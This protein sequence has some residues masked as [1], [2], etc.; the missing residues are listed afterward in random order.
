MVT[1]LLEIVVGRY[2]RFSPAARLDRD[3]IG[4]DAG[5]SSNAGAIAE[6]HTKLINYPDSPGS[7]S[8]DD[9]WACFDFGD[10]P[11]NLGRCAV[12]THRRARHSQS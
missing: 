12:P 7:L 11:R 10:F 4:R 6:A 5:L 1:K 3:A 2:A 9:G 8:I